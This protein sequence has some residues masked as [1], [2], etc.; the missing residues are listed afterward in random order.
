MRRRWA[1]V[2]ALVVLGGLAPVAVAAAPEVWAIHGVV[3]GPLGDPIAG[4]LVTDGNGGKAFTDAAGEYRIPQANVG[5]TFALRAS[6]QPVFA[7]RTASV[8]QPLPRD[9]RV[10][11]GMYYWVAGSVNPWIVSAVDGE[12]LNVEM[13]TRLD[14]LAGACGW[15]QV[16]D[17]GP[18]GDPVPL[19]VDRVDADGLQHWVGAPEL[20]VGF[21]EMHGFVRISAVQ[22]ATGQPL[23][24]PDWAYAGLIVDNTAPVLSDPR[25]SQ[26]SNSPALSAAVAEATCVTE[27][28]SSFRIDG[29]DVAFNFDEELRRIQTSGSLGL[30]DGAHDVEVIVADCAGNV[31]TLAWTARFDRTSPVV[32]PGSPAHGST[33]EDASPRLAIPAHDAAAGLDLDTARLTLS[34]GVLSATETPRWDAAAGEFWWQIPDTIESADITRRP[35]TAGTY[36]ATLALSDS[37]GNHTIHTWTFTH[38]EIL[39]DLPAPSL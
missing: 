14:D 31:G 18:A 5:G 15:A 19:T 1:L 34:N 3:T 7:D 20:P 8:Y 6:K 16:W 9:K 38:N 10:D 35:L 4:V 23:T 12:A 33:V 32:G 37:A 36:T 26:W 17:G 11:F 39:G 13:Q 24:N 21:P 30:A 27:S 29:S 28:G 22:C 2:L 25:P